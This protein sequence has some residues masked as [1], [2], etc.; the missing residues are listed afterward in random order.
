MAQTVDQFCGKWQI[1]RSTFY[2]EVQ[3]GRLRLLKIGRCTRITP[4]A[5]A[6]WIAACEANG[7]ARASAAA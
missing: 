4:D 7:R 2:A 5:E 3:D 1:S 6:D